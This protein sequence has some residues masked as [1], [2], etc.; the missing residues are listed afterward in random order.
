MPSENT[1]LDPKAIEA[2]D[3]VF[4]D[5]SVPQERT[6]ER[7]NALREHIEELTQTLEDV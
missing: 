6:K 5:T 7:L 4:Y 2:I 1:S 3:K